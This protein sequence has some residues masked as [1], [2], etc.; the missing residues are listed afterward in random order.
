[1]RC[2]GSIA[3]LLSLPLSQAAVVGGPDAPVTWE[4]LG[5]MEVTLTVVTVNSIFLCSIVPVV[6]VQRFSQKRLS[7]FG[8]CNIRLFV[9]HIYILSIILR[10]T[11]YISAPSCC[12]STRQ[13]QAHV[14][15]SV[16][17]QSSAWKASDVCKHVCAC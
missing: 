11:L 2:T 4:H 15:L 1:M 10:C 12:S 7:S 9:T 17:V 16:H 13:P 3:L 14:L 5:D 8:E 6:L